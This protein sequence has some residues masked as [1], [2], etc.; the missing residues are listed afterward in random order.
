RLGDRIGALLG[1]TLLAKGFFHGSE[2]YLGGVG[3]Y[4]APN[5]MSLIREADLVLAFGAELGHFT[6]QA[7]SLF[8]GRAVARIDSDGRARDLPAHVAVTAD[9]REAALA[10]CAALGD[11]PRA[12]FRGDETRKR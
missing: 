3:G 7:N 11:A 8:Q 6:T 12:G 9:A 2:W 1:T 10:F 4:S 5:A